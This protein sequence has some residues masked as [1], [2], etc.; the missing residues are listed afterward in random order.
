MNKFE[1][2]IKQVSDALKEAKP[3]LMGKNNQLRNE[4]GFSRTANRIIQEQKNIMDSSYNGYDV[5]EALVEGFKKNFSAARNFS[6][7]ELNST[8]DT[9]VIDVSITAAVRSSMLNYVAGERSMDAVKTNINYTGLK[10]VN[11]AGGFSAGQVVYSPVNMVSPNIDLGRSGATHR[12]VSTGAAP[13]TGI[14]LGASGATTNL[15]GPIVAGSVKVFKTADMSLIGF[16]SPKLENG[17][18][19][20]KIAT[21]DASELTGGTINTAT[22]ALVIN[23]TVADLTVQFSYDRIA[24]RNGNN[25]LRLIPF[26]TSILLSAEPRRVVLEMD[27]EVNTEMNKILREN[28]SA[29]ITVDYGKRAIDTLTDIYTTYIDYDLAR[30]LYEAVAGKSPIQTDLDLSGYDSDFKSFSATKDNILSKAVATASQKFLTT[31]GR[32]VTAL[33]VDQ[34][35]AS[36]LMSDDHNFVADPSYL[37]IPNGLIGYYKNI[38]V[39]RNIYLDNKITGKGIIIFVHKSTDSALAPVFFGS[40][41]P[42]YSTTSALNFL[43]PG[44]LSQGLFSQTASDVAIPELAEFM[45]ITPW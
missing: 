33:V 41:I 18:P 37:V 16:T 45:T 30:K 9:S 32:A 22:G 8:F 39:V 7:S 19:I 20:Q 17:N 43:N 40:Y 44:Q 1:A 38:P 21:V 11:T 10:A 27:I 2:R 3:W 36:M 14:T 5:K 24:D 25:T 23:G 12:I 34:V 42:L 13:D 6:E 28:A 29:G 35:A 26:N 4:V 31:T 15:N